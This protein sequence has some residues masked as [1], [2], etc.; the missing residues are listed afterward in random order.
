M[1]QEEESPQIDD[2]EAEA[3][4]PR[5]VPF[6]VGIG[7]SAGGLAALKTFFD[8]AQEN[9]GLSYVVVVHLS[10]QHESHLAD[11][12][13]FRVKIPV[14]QVTESTEIL[15][16]RVYFIP[17]GYNISAIDSYWS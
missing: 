2:S 4:P 8:D 16:N 15:P 5:P 3:P 13:Q 14:Q 12:L 9:S 6:V 7:A 11:L 1:G 10:A 17:P